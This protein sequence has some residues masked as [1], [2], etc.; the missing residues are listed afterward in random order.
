MN[1]I[2]S[3]YSTFV[4][5]HEKGQITQLMA[6]TYF[7]YRGW[8]T[9]T[10]ENPC[11]PYDLLIRHPRTGKSLLVQVKSLTSK[12]RSVETY[13]KGNGRDK[14]S[15]RKKTDYAKCGIDFLLGVDV[16]TSNVYLYPLDFYRGK[17]TINVD[18]NPS[19]DVEFITERGYR[20][21]K[22]HEEIS[23]LDLLAHDKS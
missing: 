14:G 6:K 9:S 3:S 8:E 4:T 12:N 15:K 21:F 2:P 1:L 11:S 19:F 16:D 18:K 20:N 13:A 10:P 5:D 7:I 17:S 22:M 23:T